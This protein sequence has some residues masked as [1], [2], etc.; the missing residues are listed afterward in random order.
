MNEVV[1]CDFADEVK[2]NQI[3]PLPQGVCNRLFIACDVQFLCFFFFFLAPLPPTVLKNAAVWQKRLGSGTRRTAVGRS[4][5]QTMCPLTRRQ[6]RTGR[7]LRQICSYYMITI[8][9]I[10]GHTQS[11]HSTTGNS[12]GK[13]TKRQTVWLLQPDCKSNRCFPLSDAADSLSVLC[14]AS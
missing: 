13:K 14:K 2:P 10:H 7:R 5:G 6:W 4:V 8:S 1:K 12:G 11:S 9:I 3:H